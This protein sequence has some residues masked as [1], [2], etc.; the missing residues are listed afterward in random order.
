[1]SEKDPV[2][3]LDPSSQ[4]VPPHAA[5]LGS[6]S[7]LQPSLRGGG[8]DPATGR[9]SPESGRVPRTN[10]D[11]TQPFPHR[12]LGVHTILNPTESQGTY[13]SS[14]S[15]IASRSVGEELGSLSTSG[16][17]GS[18]PTT[19]RP[20]VF[21][22]QGNFQAQQANVTSPAASPASGPSSS[23]RASPNVMQTH[24]A[25]GTT[26]RYLTARSPRGSIS[27]P[28]PPP[29]PGTSHQV[30][31]P[32][33]AAPGINRVF[34]ID[35]AG[36]GQPSSPRAGHPPPTALYF[37]GMNAPRSVAP[38]S[39]ALPP[40]SL[41]Q[42][43][44]APFGVPGQGS[45]TIQGPP[46]HVRTQSF[47]T[48][49]ASGSVPSHLSYPSSL[50]TSSLR[51]SGSFSSITHQGI[52]LADGQ[53][54][55]AINPEGGERMLI[56]VNTNHASKAADE[57]R[58]R[59][60]GASARF[61]QRKKDKEEEK[62][63]RLRRLENQSRELERQNRDLEAE[64]ERMR[65]DRNRLRDI[66]S[67]APGISDLAYQGPPSPRPRRS[68]GPF[69]ERSPLAPAVTPAPVAGFTHAVD[70]PLAGERAPR[71]RRTDSQL[72]YPMPA[73]VT[74][75]VTLQPGHPA[76]AA[77]TTPLPQPGTPPAVPPSTL[78]PLRLEPSSGPPPNSGPGPGT[79][80]LNFSYRREP[81]EP[82]W[83]ARPSGPRDP[84]H[85]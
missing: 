27:N 62:E 44:T 43:T 84:G 11:L 36:P 5:T 79:G 28:G 46:G 65:A 45:P 39:A 8:G 73:Y 75:P 80:P 76:A 58:Q 33:T 12:A 57:K 71:R 25:V 40:R 78:P 49:Y 67:Q 15:P 32:H 77:Y 30:S 38:T 85:R 2:S 24:P 72:G 52:T 74:T 14:S 10:G 47:S 81:Y 48:P 1:M 21:Q 82:G 22:G 35:S 83:A 70:D 7:S 20:Y 68:D 4:A 13:A 6:P 37:G 56:P 61:R 17:Y 18:S 66:V 63:M 3:R 54:I 16:Q 51:W 64:L 23:D 41:S 31:F 50:P 29:R 42:P 53:P 60:A 9:E 34:Q 59:N 69:L 55:L 26:R 19:Q